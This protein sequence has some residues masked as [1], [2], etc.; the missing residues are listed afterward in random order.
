[1]NLFQDYIHQSTS[2]EVR[3]VAIAALQMGKGDS[4]ELVVP[5]GIKPDMMIEDHYYTK[6]EYSK[7]TKEQQWGLRLKWAKHGH[8]KED[9]MP[10]QKKDGG[11]KSS[12][13]ELRKWMI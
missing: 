4:E 2:L 11:Q 7:L 1:M 8:K 13:V 3:E 10:E 5:M 12:K 9:K 6:K